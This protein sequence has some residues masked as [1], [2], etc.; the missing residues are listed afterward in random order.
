MKEIIGNTPMIKI[1]YEYE[2]QKRCL[3]AKLEYYNLTGSIKDRM[4]YYVL[5][6]NKENGNIKP[7]VP[8]VE[9]TSGNTGISLAAIGA[10]LNHPVHIF[11]PDFVSK[12]RIAL[13]KLYGANVNLISKEEGGYE[14]CMKKALAFS[15]NKNAYLL[16]QFETPL[17]ITAHYQGT[18]TEIIKKL[19]KVDAFVS[20]F[21]TGGTLMGVGLKIKEVSDS[22]HI[23]AIEPENM[24]L[25]DKNK[26]I[27]I[28]KI[29]GIADGFIPKIVDRSIIDHTYVVKEN[30]AICM[31]QKLSKELGIGVGIS[32]GAN[33]IGSILSVEEFGGNV[34][35]VFPD[36]SKKYLSTDLV[37]KIPIEP[38]FISNKVQ[39]INYESI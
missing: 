32:S 5:M 38:D 3:Y 33:L 18:G 36:D 15:K 39:F 9:A 19:E 30:D 37:K 35:T 28:H 17:N 6:K 31:C 10:F 8:L 16:N 11:I 1:N 14:T 26:K 22:A 21:G 29:E 34:C 7:R 12:E 2:G 20:G 27:G 23:V 25:L 24:T 13:M 4:V